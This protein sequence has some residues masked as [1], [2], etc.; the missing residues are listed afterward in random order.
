MHENNTTIKEQVKLAQALLGRK[1]ERN[2]CVHHINFVRN[3]NVPENLIVM[4]H[5][6]H[7]ALH[8]YLYDRYLYCLANHFDWVKHIEFFTLHWIKGRYAIK[9]WEL[10]LEETV[11]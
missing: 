5:N 7:S 6:D 9:L 1:L 4:Y 10:S 3:C 8:A 11:V 2:E